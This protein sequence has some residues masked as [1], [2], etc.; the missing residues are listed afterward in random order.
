MMNINIEEENGASSEAT[1]LQQNFNQLEHK[2]MMP[3]STRIFDQHET[4]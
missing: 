3:K 4:R 1:D 2:G